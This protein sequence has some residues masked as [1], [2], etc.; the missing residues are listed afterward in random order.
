M[1]ASLISLNG[2]VKN[3]IMTQK[4]TFIPQTFG[5]FSIHIKKLK[6]QMF[7]FK[8]SYHKIR[9]VRSE[10]SLLRMH[11]HLSNA[12]YVDGFQTDLKMFFE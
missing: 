3:H 1:P 7:Y 11:R 6:K 4:A 10:R 8:W 2:T 5:L 12:Q 9:N